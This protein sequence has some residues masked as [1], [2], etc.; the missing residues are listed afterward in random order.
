MQKPAKRRPVATA[1]GQRPWSDRG[2][3]A[4]LMPRGWADAGVD[5]SQPNGR[6][7]FVVSTHPQPPQSPD[8]GEAPSTRLPAKGKPGGRSG[9]RSGN[10]WG[11]APKYQ[12]SNQT[13]TCDLMIV[14]H[15]KSKPTSIQRPTSTLMPSADIGDV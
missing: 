9:G 6:K 1:T 12:R 11:P 13:L 8:H 3:D 14:I 15:P 4:S 2:Y 5:R 10:H 7:L